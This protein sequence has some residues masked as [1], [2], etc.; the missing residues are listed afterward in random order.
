M[1]RLNLKLFVLIG[2]FVGACASVVQATDEYLI[3]V[4]KNHRN[5]E[6]EIKIFA[7]GNP[8]RSIFSKSFF[9]GQWGMEDQELSNHGLG[10]LLQRLTCTPNN[11]ILHGHAWPDQTQNMPKLRI[12]TFGSVILN[13]R[14]FSKCQGRSSIQIRV[15]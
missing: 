14:I 10:S 13:N 12:E 8:R 2:F 7:P 11:L 4:T 3:Q 6:N 5:G 15:E 1:Y 9:K